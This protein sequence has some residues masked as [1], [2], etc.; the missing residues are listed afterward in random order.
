M[1]LFQKDSVPE[2]NTTKLGNSPIFLTITH[3]TPFT[4]WFRSYGI[5]TTYITAVSF[6]DRT[7]ADRDLTFG[8]WIDRNSGSPKYQ[9]GRKLPQ[10]SNG[11]SNGSKRLVIYELR[12]LETRP[13]V[14]SE[15]L[16]RLDLPV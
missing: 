13:V 4:K 12:L 6:L 5:L 10:L 14:E 16:G 9:I 15:F 11:P 3:T 7:A 1:E 2:L 8:L